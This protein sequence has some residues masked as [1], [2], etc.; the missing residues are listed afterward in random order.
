MDIQGF[1]TMELRSHVLAKQ[2][3]TLDHGRE[4]ALKGC[5]ATKLQGDRARRRKLKRCLSIH[6]GS[7]WYRAPEVSLIERQ[8]D[9]AS[10]MW[11]FGCILFE[12]LKYFTKDVKTFEKNF[13]KERYVFQGTSCFPLSPCKNDKN[14]EIN[15]ES[16]DKDGKKKKSVG[17]QDQIKVILRG[18]GAQTDADLSFLTSDHAITYV[19]ELTVF[20][21]DKKTTTDNDS[22]PQQLLSKT[23]QEM[24]W[25]I[26]TKTREL[27]TI[28]MN[29]LSLNPYFRMTAVECLKM[30]VFDTV[31]DKTKEKVLN[32]LKSKRGVYH[33]NRAKGSSKASALGRGI[34]LDVDHAAAF[35]YE[36][37][38]NAKYT[39]KDI[40]QML[41]REILS[42]QRAH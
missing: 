11:S 18:L 13:Q 42:I 5:I 9:Q 33:K 8:Y 20:L 24:T 19:K 28:L 39:V 38:E 3:N 29:C 25:G 12:L 15:A 32:L 31:R 34:Q 35:D 6:V 7:R 26:N 16:K 17:Q 30:S 4:E 23:C 27:L 1:N 2:E 37:P 36:Q 21:S 14:D 22:R 41:A 40:K 10:D